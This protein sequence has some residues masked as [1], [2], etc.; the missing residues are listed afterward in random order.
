MS[1]DDTYIKVSESE[2]RGPV[3]ESTR[4]NFTVSPCL[5]QLVLPASRP[6]LFGQPGHVLTVAVGQTVLSSP[7]ELA[8]A[9]SRLLSCM[10][11]MSPSAR[12]LALSDSACH[13][14]QCTLL[15]AAA[16]HSS[17]PPLSRQ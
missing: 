6:S 7:V 16:V 8:Q 1:D 14:R 17:L 11:S 12:L 15:T 9:S 3:S 5:A 2:A 4:V 13:F 10:L